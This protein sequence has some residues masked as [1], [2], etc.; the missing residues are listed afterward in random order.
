MFTEGTA[1]VTVDVITGD[2]NSN[3]AFYNLTINHAGTTTVSTN[4]LNVDGTLTLASTATLDSSTGPRNVSIGVNLTIAAGATFTTGGTTATVTFDGTAAQVITTGLSAV[5]ADAGNDFQNVTVSNSTAAVSVATNPIEIDGDLTIAALGELALGAQAMTLTG[6]LSNAN[7]AVLSLD[8]SQAITIGTMDTNTGSVNYIGAG[9]YTQLAAGDNY[10]DLALN[11]TGSITLDA[12]LDINGDLSVIST[13]TFATGANAITIADDWTVA[14]TATFSSGTGTVTFNGAEAQTLNSGGG[15]TSHDFYNIVTSGAGTD[16][17]LSTSALRIVNDLTIATG[18]IW[19]DNGIN[20]TILG[21]WA[22]S[23]TYT[24]EGTSMV[25]F[26]SASTQSLASGASGVANDDDFNR[27]TLA[28]NTTLT[29][30]TNPLEIDSTLTINTGAILDISGVNLTL[31]TA[32]DSVGTLKLDGSE[33]V[34]QSMM[35]PN[36]GTVF[37]D[38]T[39][40]YASGLVAGDAYYNLTINGTGGSWTLDAALDVNGLMTIVAGT[41]VANNLAINV[42]GGWSQAAG[43]F[44]PG[45]ATVTF[46]GA[47]TLTKTTGA[48]NDVTFSS[49]TVTLG[50]ALDVDDDVTVTTGVLDVSATNYA[51]S[52]GG[53][54][55]DAG[56][57]TF[58]EQGGTVT[59]DGST[60]GGTIT[61]DDNFENLVINDTGN[62]ITLGAALDVDSQ[63]VLTLGT[64]DV[65]ASN[66]AMTVGGGW[67]D[68]GA[69]AF[70]ER[71]GTVT[72]DG[73]GTLSSNEAFNDVAFSSGTVTLGAALDVDDDLA[74]SGGTLDVGATNFGIT[75]GGDWSRSSGTFTQQSGTVDLD[76]GASAQTMTGST[77][78]YGLT[79]TETA[80]STLYVTA[81]DTMTAS[82]TLTLTGTTGALIT[83]ESTSAGTVGIINAPASNVT[84]THIT[85]RDIQNTGTTIQ[86]STSCINR[87]NNPGWNITVEQTSSG[88][89]GGGGGGATSSVNLTSPNGGE[90]YAFGQK[91]PIKWSL[92]GTSGKSVG[93]F[94]STDGGSKY[95]KIADGLDTDDVSYTWTVPSIL[96]LKAKVKVVSY[97]SS[98]REVASDESARTF[99]IQS[100]SVST[101]DTTSDDTSSDT[102]DQTPD[103]GA[104]ADSTFEGIEMRE[105]DGDLVT[106]TPGGLF[107][108]ETLSSVYYVDVDGRRA[109][110]PN[111]DVF[112]S[113]GFSFDNVVTVDDDQLQKLALGR[114]LRMNAGSL[115]KIQSDPKVYEVGSDGLLHHVPDEATAKAL[116]G[117]GWA[118]LIKDVNV[119]FW[120]DYSFGDALTSEG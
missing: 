9:T 67:S 120:G 71:A 107:R 8:G 48:F 113:Y 110:F 57:G 27:I 82:N 6:T 77:T 68:T 44:T 55:T 54:W 106:L 90:S 119:V 35:D 92:T 58:T 1:T 98:S 116:Y 74:I 15:D 10:Y 62:T 49:G 66:Y 45:T 29:V 16:I 39:G 50:G 112:N 61:T 76:G 36:S 40:T 84:V 59:F 21:D 19:D 47:G 75:L 63:M 17:Q 86:C 87:G 100:A 94:Y 73:A 31:G 108:G 111:E 4:D 85:V 89:G 43:T 18:T 118:K 104:E 114:R 30:L 91:V 95:T 70:T 26:D 81:G 11:G 38:G 46:D 37:Y 23:G 22:N 56:A 51:I 105:T 53:D 60:A 42:A 52:V 64:L 24:A 103:T 7:T 80:S 14:G 41:L 69:G 79:K 72:F 115:I 32:I 117:S 96:S 97:N 3:E 12:T 88:G 83:M 34:T 101:D 28:D 99:T 5:G 2:I 20:T 78:F 65:S 109:V 13:Q 25:S 93:L 102:G 33:T